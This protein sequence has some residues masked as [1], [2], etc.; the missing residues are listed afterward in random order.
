MYK[1]AFRSK[2]A[3]YCIHFECCHSWQCSANTMSS[4]AIIKFKTK[5]NKQPQAS[6]YS[7]RLKALMIGSI[8][9]PYPPSNRHAALF[10][11]KLTWCISLE[12]NQQLWMPI[13]LTSQG[14][15]DPPCPHRIRSLSKPCYRLM[16]TVAFLPNAFVFGFRGCWGEVQNHC[17]WTEKQ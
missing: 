13:M 7:K 5:I 1:H 14:Y 6:N 10:S 12:V 9:S 16:S 15:V 2:T 17:Y 4:L 3:H 8:Q 11:A